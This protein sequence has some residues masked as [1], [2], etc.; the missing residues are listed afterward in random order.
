MD[1][2]Q[3]VF[4]QQNRYKFWNWDELFSYT[5]LTPSEI[6]QIVDNKEYKLSD[7][8]SILVFSHKNHE[9]RALDN[10]FDNY[11]N[12]S[13]FE[14]NYNEYGLST[15]FILRTQSPNWQN[16]NLNTDW[17][18]KQNWIYKYGQ[19]LQML[20]GVKSVYLSCSVAMENSHQGSDIDL[21]IQVHK[22]CVWITK[23]YFAILSKI[24]KYYDLN[25]GLAVLYLFTN[26]TK[27]LEIL[28]YKNIKNKIKID[29]GMVF[30]GESD[31][32]KY[33]CNRER[34][35]FVWSALK[36]N[37]FSNIQIY[38]KTLNSFTSNSITYK[39]LLS[40]CSF[41]LIKILLYPTTLLILPFG[42]LNFTFEQ[43][44]KSDYNKLVLWKIY[45]QY[46]LVY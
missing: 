12:P 37:S 44:N 29:F 41:N 15:N 24:L 7:P 5:K 2:Y 20:P 36:L 10:I 42:L 38:A 32:V 34:N 26:Q 6:K 1:L 33:Y 14:L 31:V 28:K 19:L 16:Y 39:P 8:L 13:N 9:Q 22:N 45:S 46:N 35:I 30:E 4:Q 21:I 27:K 25:F 40:N 17:Y 43:K 18:W 3:L 11:T 23:P